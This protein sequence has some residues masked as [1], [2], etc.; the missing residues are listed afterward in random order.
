MDS[1]LEIGACKGVR[2]ACSWLCMLLAI[3]STML[4]AADDPPSP[5]SPELMH[6]YDPN[7]AFVRP[8]EPVPVQHIEEQFTLPGDHRIFSRHILIPVDWEHDSPE[9]LTLLA[10]TAGEIADEARENGWDKGASGLAYRREL[11]IYRSGRWPNIYITEANSWQV[12]MHMAFAIRWD[13]T[14][15]P[16]EARFCGDNDGHLPERIDCVPKPAIGGYQFPRFFHYDRLNSRDNQEVLRLLAMMMWEIVGERTELKFLSGR[17]P[18]LLFLRE[19]MTGAAEYGLYKYSRR[20]PNADALAEF[21]KAVQQFPFDPGAVR[22]V[23]RSLSIPDGE[24]F[25]EFFP[26]LLTDPTFQPYIAN[27]GVYAHISDTYR[28]ASME[29]DRW[30]S[31]SHALDL[32][33]SLF[34]FLEGFG[35]S[36]RG[37]E[38]LVQ[39]DIQGVTTSYFET[40]VTR[41]LERNKALQ[42]RRAV[43]LPRSQWLYSLTM[44]CRQYLSGVERRMRAFEQARKNSSK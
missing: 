7:D 19:M 28:T 34:S 10:A 43:Y 26:Q 4:R 18:S 35:I 14:P 39:T 25:Q 21:T 36:E 24:M 40:Q 27:S 29:T 5:H 32:P 13:D 1:R 9:S 33:Q 30:R 12:L 37:R 44:P 41:A 8:L 3:A 16:W 17:E 42:R 6:S 2:A 11:A 15:L 22:F 20:T 38:E 31:L 23:A